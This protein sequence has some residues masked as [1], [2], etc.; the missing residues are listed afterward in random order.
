MKKRGAFVWRDSAAGILSVICAVVAGLVG[1][2]QRCDAQGTAPVALPSAQFSSGMAGLASGQTARLNVVN[3]G[4]TTTSPIPCVLV[5]AFLDSDGKI[6]KQ[7][8]AS[9]AS[10]QAAFVDLAASTSAWGRRLEIRGIGYNPLLSPVAVSCNLVPTLELFDTETGKTAAIL[11][12][13]R[14][15]TITPIATPTLT[16]PQ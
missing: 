6:L 4:P 10:G 11:A 16:P 5:L 2:A 9:V 7:M 1:F 15:S 12:D 8:V 3:I 14:T 13:F